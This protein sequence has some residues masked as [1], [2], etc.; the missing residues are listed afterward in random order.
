[1]LAEN[2]CLPKREIFAFFECFAI[3]AL[4]IL[5]QTSGFLGVGES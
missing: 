5:L 3:F 1:M 4:R 2:K